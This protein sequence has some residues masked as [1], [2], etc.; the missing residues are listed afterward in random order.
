MPCWR[1]STN[2]ALSSVG[3]GAGAEATELAQLLAALGVS[4]LLLVASPLR[5]TAILP[6]EALAD[7]ERSLHARLEP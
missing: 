1:G 2:G 3:V 5:V 7:A 4:P 6:L